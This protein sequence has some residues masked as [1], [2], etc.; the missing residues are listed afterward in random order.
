M[1]KLPADTPALI[2]TITPELTKTY[3]I[4]VAETLNN[5]VIPQLE[6][7]ARARANDCLRIVSRLVSNSSLS[8]KTLELLSH[9]AKDAIAAAL[10]DGEALENANTEG[11][12]YLASI[13]AAPPAAGRSVDHVELE[14]Y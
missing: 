9:D 4:N 3:L 1:T 14:A 5:L 2:S 13:K 12:A 6:G 10:I 7:Q 11:V 8:D